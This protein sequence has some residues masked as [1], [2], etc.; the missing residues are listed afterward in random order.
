M[1]VT[2]LQLT[3][4]CFFSVL[5]RIQSEDIVHVYNYDNFDELF[6]QGNLQDFNVLKYQEIDILFDKPY[7]GPNIGGAFLLHGESN[8]NTPQFDGYIVDITASFYCGDKKGN[9]VRFLSFWVGYADD[10]DERVFICDDYGWN[11]NYTWIPPQRFD[12]SEVS[13]QSMPSEGFR[14]KAPRQKAPGQKPPDNKPLV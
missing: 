8:T 11:Y 3:I 2:A 7:E 13:V 10:R 12:H 9:K 4:I 5:I 14:S 1:K 6:H